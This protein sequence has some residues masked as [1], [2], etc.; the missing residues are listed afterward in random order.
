M[1]NHP[2]I[3]KPT[4]ENQN[5]YLQTLLMLLIITIFVNFS[6][7]PSANAGEPISANLEEIGGGVVS[8]P[9][10]CFQMGSPPNEPGHYNNETLHLVCLN[11]F[12]ITRREI[13]N[14][15]F[16]RFRPD[17]DSGDYEGV[18]LNDSNQP[19]VRVSWHDGVAFAAWLSSQ[20]GKRYRLPTEA[21]WEYAAR[22]GTTTSRYWGN[23][24]HQACQYANVSD[25]S[26][27]RRWPR[28]YGHHCDDGYPVTA[29][30]GSFRANAFGLYDMLGNVWEWTCSSFAT[31]YDGSETHCQTQGDGLR[32]F[33]GGAWFD[34][35]GWVRT[36]LRASSPPD[37]RYGLLGF[38]LARDP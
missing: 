33:R 14:Q 15:D 30:V 23:N 35:P 10:G 8:L 4:L 9:G 28:W 20:S 16:R 22:G 6:D 5:S 3:K 2:I 37:N 25:S 19:V 1:G 21:E 36:A 29:P 38:R 18:S 24:P 7:A 31:G 27:T 12:S 34:G 32:V 11:P 26:A 17:H 13:T